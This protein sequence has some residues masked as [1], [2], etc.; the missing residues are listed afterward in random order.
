[1]QPDAGGGDRLPVDVILDVAA[2]EHAGDARLRAVVRDDVAVRVELELAAEERRVRRVAD[3]HEHA[4]HR[5]LAFARRS[6]SSRT[7]IAVT[8]PLP[9]SLISSTSC[10][11]QP[12]DLRVR[13]R[14]VLH[15]LRRAQRVAAMDDGDLRRRSASGRPLLP[16]PSRRRRRRRSPGRGRSSRRR[17]RRSRRRGPSASRSD[18]S[19]SSRADAPVAMI[20]VFARDTRR[21]TS[22]RRTAGAEIDARSRCPG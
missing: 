4:G 20:S 8:S 18:G 3:R 15:D 11:E 17:S 6:C 9:V 14:L 5:H 10:V 7:T 12:R 13:A 19:P 2:G 1:M 16:S 21:R 22:S